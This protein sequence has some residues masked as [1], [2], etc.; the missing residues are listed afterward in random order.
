MK[1]EPTQQI[2]SVPPPQPPSSLKE[3]D[4][5]MP[6]TSDFVKKLYKMLED[7]TFSHVVSWGPQGDCFVVKDMNEFTKSILPRMFKHS[8][9]ASFVR[10]LNKYDF[11]KVKTTDD[12][13][14]GEHSWTFRHPDFHADRRDALENIKRKVPAARKSLP[15]SSNGGFSGGGRGASSGSPIPGESSAELAAVQAHVGV[16]Q[17]S[18]QSLA[19]ER[20]RVLERQ[21][22]DVLVEMVNFQ[23]G[24]AQQD[25]LMQG[26]IQYFLGEGGER[27]P[28]SGF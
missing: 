6:A 12:A 23:K 24:M 14:F 2:H 17:N 8:N 22:G 11:H 25:G 4:D 5:T 3:Q 18:Y 27:F 28:C 21:Y 19:E 15:S 20:I 16:L 7:H 9:F 1:R 26:L 10:Q 13:Q